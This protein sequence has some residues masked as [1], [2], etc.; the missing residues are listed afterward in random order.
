MI[1]IPSTKQ[2]LKGNLKE[3][4]QI[5][6]AQRQ[7]GGDCSLSRYREM[8]GRRSPNTPSPPSLLSSPRS[9]SFSTLTLVQGL[10][11]MIFFF[12]HLLVCSLSQMPAS[13]YLLHENDKGRIVPLLCHQ[14]SIGRHHVEAPRGLSRAHLGLGSVLLPQS[15]CAVVGHNPPIPKEYWQ[16]LV[17]CFVFC[18]YIHVYVRKRIQGSKS[19]I[20]ILHS[21]S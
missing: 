13:T 8:K 4:I 6:S 12:P 10:Q 21:C 18:V 5:C 9:L 3:F 1:N 15:I 2:S 16:L 17:V 14:A 11:Y 7:A 20:D 19:K